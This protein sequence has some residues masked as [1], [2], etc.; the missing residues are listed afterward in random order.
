MPLVD[1]TE[2]CFSDAV[3]PYQSVLS[4]D[5][6]ETVPHDLS[7]TGHPLR[8]LGVPSRLRVQEPLGTTAQPLLLHAQLDGLHHHGT[9]CLAG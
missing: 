3:L 5:L 6:R 7:R 8:G 9:V 1:D 4:Q 2:I